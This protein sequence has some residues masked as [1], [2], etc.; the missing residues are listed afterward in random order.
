LAAFAELLEAI[1][2]ELEFGLAGTSRHWGDSPAICI[3]KVQ[4]RK[5]PTTQFRNKPSKTKIQLC[6]L[7]LL[8]N[9]FRARGEISSGSVEGL[10]NRVKLALKKA[11]GFKSYTA[12]EI[13]LYHQLGKLPVPNQ[14]HRFCARGKKSDPKEPEDH[15]LGRSRNVFSTKIH[16]ACDASELPPYLEITPGQGHE[17]T[18]LID[19]LNGTDE[20]VT[21]SDAK[22]LRG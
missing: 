7:T 4:Q 3:A 13:A 22:R 11:Y 6:T 12:V 5:K 16:L 14:P 19:L 1:F 18:S 2:P 9:R 8:L 15:D 17:G 20:Q 21:G 10:N